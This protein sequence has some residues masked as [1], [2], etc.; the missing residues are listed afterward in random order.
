MKVRRITHLAAALTLAGLA[1]SALAAAPIKIAIAGPV[2]GSVAQYG[3]MQRI[4]ALAAI[5]QINKAGGINGSKLEGVIYD[6]ACD[7]KQAVAVANK[8]VND[9]IKLVVGHVCS[10]ATEAASNVYE[11]EGV[12]MMS[13]SATAPSITARGLKMVFRATGLDSVQGPIAAKYIIANYKG[14]NVAVL[15]DKQQYGEGLGNTVKKMVEAG[16]VK[17][18]LYEGLNAGDKDYN[19]LITKL[20][21]ANVD[22]VYFGGYHPEMGLLLRQARQAG[23]KAQFMGPEGVGNKD[24]SAIAGE[25]SE[26]MLTT[27]PKAFEL[28]PKN[29]AIVDTI[30]AKK[31]DPAGIFV[32]PYY[33]AVQVLADSIKKIGGTDTKKIAQNLRASNFDTAIGNIGFDAKGDVKNFSYVVYRW[34]KNGTKTEVK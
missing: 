16:G 34:H 28:D 9:K 17:V 11:D 12:L 20:K 4:G 29:K 25:A 23:L 8:V 13:A 7:P 6:D 1:N 18:A 15:H 3:D 31:Q 22:F 24:L 5:E 2:T 30:K 21:R 27:L 33:A 14:K 19:A 10:G 26:G 32:M